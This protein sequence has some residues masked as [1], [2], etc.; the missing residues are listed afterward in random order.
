MPAHK[1]YTPDFERFWKVFPRGRKSKKQEAFR[2]WLKAIK[3]GMN[4][5]DIIDMAQ[6]YAESWLGQSE[7]V[8]GPAPWLYQ[9]RWEDDPVSWNNP[10]T[11]NGG[12]L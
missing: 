6:V 11:S 4:P 10:K 1:P 7:F 5:E 8:S 9:S 3:D 2:N 12:V